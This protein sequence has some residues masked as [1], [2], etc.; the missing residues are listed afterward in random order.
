LN[1]CCLYAVYAKPR[2]SQVNVRQNMFATDKILSL[3]VTMTGNFC[4][5]LFF[6][7]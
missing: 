5:I 3:S 2:L 4:Q 7:Q 6:I 1:M